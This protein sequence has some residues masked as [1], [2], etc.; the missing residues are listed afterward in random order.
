MIGTKLIFMFV[1]N[2][3]QF[4]FNLRYDIFFLPYHYSISYHVQVQ[5]F[6]L[7]FF[8]VSSFRLEMRANIAISQTFVRTLSI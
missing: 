6:I 4:P 5:K 8:Q 2:F 7:T 1:L 3:F